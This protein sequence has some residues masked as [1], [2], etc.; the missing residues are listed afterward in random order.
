[1][2]Y[3]TRQAIRLHES[4][5]IST[6]K[7]SEVRS[8]ICYS[9]TRIFKLEVAITVCGQDSYVFRYPDYLELVVAFQQGLFQDYSANPS[10][11]SQ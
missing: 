1:M 11:I 4:T 6:H 5:C 7:H 8:L 9:R 3:M 10:L 2:H